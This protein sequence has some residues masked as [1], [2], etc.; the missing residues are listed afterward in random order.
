MYIKKA[1]YLRRF[2]WDASLGTQYLGRILA[3]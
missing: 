3:R 1:Q 2:I